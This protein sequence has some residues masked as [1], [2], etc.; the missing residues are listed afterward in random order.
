MLFDETEYYLRQLSRPPTGGVA[1][2]R[3]DVLLSRYLERRRAE[4]QLSH[5][6]ASAARRRRLRAAATV[7]PWIRRYLAA[8]FRSLASQGRGGARR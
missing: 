7:F 3:R 4:A 5:R 8:A 2:S 1:P 6:A